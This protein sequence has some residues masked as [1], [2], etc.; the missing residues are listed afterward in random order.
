MAVEQR[1]G[2]IHRYGQHDTVQVYTL[3]AEDTV[4]ERIYGL[5]EEKLIEIAQTIGKVDP[6]TGEVLEDFRSEILGF[7]GSSPNY[8]DLFKKALVDRDYKR[9]EREMIEAIERARKASEALRTLTQ[10]LET[11][12]LDHYR[13]IRGHFSLDHLRLFVE[14][15]IL[16]LGGAFI[17]SAEVVH[18]ETPDV[19]LSYPGVVRTYRDATFHRDLAMRRRNVHFLGLGHP[20]VDALIRH[21]QRPQQSGDVSTLRRPRGPHGCLSIRAM[22]H[23]G[24]ENGRRRSLYAQF[25][26]GP[27]GSWQEAPP[28]FDVERLANPSSERGE[29]L[30]TSELGTSRSA[31]QQALAAAE[32][33]LRAKTDGVMSI[34]HTLVGLAYLQ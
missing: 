23:M 24:L 19:L 7:L 8:Q 17:P 33:Q 34:R 16:R 29:E 20:L 27:D 18:I 28:T 2:R 13:T 15:A 30:D 1:I 25:V 32:A 31:V 26:L 10:D 3:V 22:F 11:F 5:L 9:T 14:A 12:N 6:V 21:F 4:E